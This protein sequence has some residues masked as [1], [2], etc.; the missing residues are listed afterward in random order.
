[1][2]V[3]KLEQVLRARFAGFTAEHTP[4]LESHPAELAEGRLCHVF[5]V[6][7]GK[8]DVTARISEVLERAGIRTAVLRSIVP[9]TQR[10]AWYA[11]K[12]AATPKEEKAPN[13]VAA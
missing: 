2:Q 13:G 1:M 5:A 3:D 8:N 9:T 4:P 11:K 6:Y 7:T 10:E 12:V